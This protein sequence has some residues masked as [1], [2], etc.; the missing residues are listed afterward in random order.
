VVV[1]AA[2]G[3]AVRAVRPGFD[4]SAIQAAANGRTSTGVAI[5]RIFSDLGSF[6]LLAPLAA[7]IIL[8]R[9]L[10]RPWED[11]VLVVIALGSAAIPS[12]IKLIVQRPRPSVRLLEHLS[13]LSFPSEHTTQ[14][15]AIY[16]A[17]ALILTRGWPQ[18]W[19][20]VAL[21]AAVLVALLV[22]AARVYLGD[23]FPSDVIAGL[24]LGWA[25]SWLV[26]EWGA[27][28][29]ASGGENQSPADRRGRVRTG[30][31]P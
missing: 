16:S 31:S 23:H 27:H 9:R 5:M 29:S 26:L 19:R 10:K 21:G 4:L 18:R 1:G 2:A 7:A 17:M 22:G 14:A 28:R 25:W 6:A 12:V 8:L 24:L 13:S 11:V 15:A 3:L 30:D 20:A